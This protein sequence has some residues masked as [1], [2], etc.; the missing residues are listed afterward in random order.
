MKKCYIESITSSRPHRRNNIMPTYQVTYFNAKH[1]V[2]DS[3]AIFMKNL[4]NAKR[5]A[6]HHAPEGTDQIEIKDL[7]DQV[8]TRLTSEQGWIDSTE[9]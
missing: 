8:L 4:T 3:E 7:M 1:A 9:E 5:S 6:E 2:M